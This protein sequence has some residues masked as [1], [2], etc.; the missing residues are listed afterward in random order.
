MGIIPSNKINRIKV[1]GIRA[2]F[3]SKA[4]FTENSTWYSLLIEYTDG[5]RELLEVD[6]KKMDKYLPYIDMDY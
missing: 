5:R 6:T 2:A 3:Q 4:I 1:L